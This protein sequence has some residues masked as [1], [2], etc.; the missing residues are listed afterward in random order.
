MHPAHRITA[1]S[2]AVWLKTTDVHCP[3]SS[4][5][6]ERNSSR[7]AGGADAPPPPT[8]QA[9]PPSVGATVAIPP[10]LASND[11]ARDGN[12]TECVVVVV[13]VVWWWEWCSVATRS[14]K[15]ETTKKK[16]K[17]PVGRNPIVELIC[18][19]NSRA[20]YADKLAC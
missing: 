11:R 16:I 15:S 19:R 8:N 5:A 13:V 17:Y 4:D 18:G 20:A 3:L 14:A 2:T 12:D 9:D 7:H 6:P 10:L 1:T